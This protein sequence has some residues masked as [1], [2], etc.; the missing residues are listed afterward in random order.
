[1]GDMISTEN[2][3]REKL[4]RP[5]ITFRMG[6]ILIYLFLGVF[7]VIQLYPLVY[8]FFFS[9]KSNDEIM[10]GNVAG[11]PQQWLW[12]NYAKVLANGDLPR[13]FLNSV[14]VTSSTILLV[15]GLGGG[16]A[17]A[18]QRMRWKLSKATLILFLLGI[19]IPFHAAL[20]PLFKILS[21]LNILDSY[22]ALILPY[23]AFG[24]PVAI[25]I[26]TGFFK[27]VPYEMEESACLD[28]CNIYQT[29]FH[30]IMPMVK[31]AIVTIAIFTYRN[32][33]NELMFAVSFISKKAFKTIPFGLMALNGRYATQWG[34][35][36]AALLM[37][38]LPSLIIYFILSKQVQDSVRAGAIKG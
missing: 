5:K 31:P 21:K 35:I 38:S 16:A 28:G 32:A 26:F 33:W 17:Y 22:L 11:L 14:I 13:Y 1:M 20:L 27:S 2:K 8:L 30:I 18:I 23:V 24:L 3:L 25:F 15:I 37:A 36:G 29:F 34:P 10:G 9:L 7:T 19:M 4:I 12:K 6:T